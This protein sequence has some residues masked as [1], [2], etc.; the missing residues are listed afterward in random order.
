METT[1][2]ILMVCLGNIC[3]SP[4]AEGILRHKARLRNIAI[5]TDSAGTS[6]WHVGEPADRRAIA[7][8]KEKGIDIS[9]LRSRPFERSDFSEF[10]HIFVMDASNYK[11]VMELAR[12]DDDRQKVDMMM[13][14]LYPNQNIIVPDPYFNDSFERVYT[15]LDEAVD[16]LLDKL[17]IPKD[18]V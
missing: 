11:D 6:G 9:D 13:N 3:R 17:S 10:D 7:N 15:M 5:E 16:A 14:V 12:D 4:M 1:P 2:R 8:L 18:A